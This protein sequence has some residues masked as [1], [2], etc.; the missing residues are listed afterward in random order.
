MISLLQRITVPS[1][2]SP[3]TQDLCNQFNNHLSELELQLASL[4]GSDGQTASI[5]SDIDLQGK[6]LLNVGTPQTSNSAINANT[7]RQSN[8]FRNSIK[9]GLTRSLK[10]TSKNSSSLTHTV[11]R[12]EVN[13]SI[14]RSY[15]IAIAAAWPVGSIFTSAVATNPAS[16]L[17][18]G[19]W[20][21][22]AQ[23][24]F[25][26]GYKSADPDF[27]TVLATGGSKT[28]THAVDPATTTSGA[29]SATETVD[30]VGGGATVSVASA[31]HTHDTDIGSTTSGT[32]SDLPPFFVVYFWRRTA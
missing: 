22:I 23:G 17:G 28:H 4:K 29:P 8:S 7:L 10:V 1:N 25:L 6:S 15:G 13:A 5:D 18:F 16:L 12:A 2:A 9:Q 26:V 21:Q 20:S 31:T 19:T 27:G 30:D 24:Q 3:E 32:N 14:A 11:N